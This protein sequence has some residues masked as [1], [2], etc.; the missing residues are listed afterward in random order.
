[1]NIPAVNC[2]TFH[3]NGINKDHKESHDNSGNVSPQNAY[4]KH[5]L[6]EV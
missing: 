4:E 1:M 5:S 6:S 3:T 2:R